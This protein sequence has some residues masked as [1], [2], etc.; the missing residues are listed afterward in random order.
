MSIV[1]RSVERSLLAGW[2]SPSDETPPESRPTGTSAP[3]AHPKPSY[4]ELEDRVRELDRLIDQLSDAKMQM[5]DFLAAAAHDL[6]APLITI[7]HNATFARMNQGDSIT[8][9]TAECLDRIQSAEEDMMD[10]LK[11]ISDVS[12]AGHDTESR[13]LHSSWVLAQSSLRQL[14]GTIAERQAQVTVDDNL[15]DLCCQATKFVQVFSNLISNAIKYTPAERTPRVEVGCRRLSDGESVFFV[16]DNG[17]GI[18]ED[19]LGRVFGIFDR[20]SVD[21]SIPGQGLGLAVV[22]RIIGLHGGRIW[23]ESTPG[24]GSTFYFTV[25]THE[26]DDHDYNS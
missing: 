15:P 22:K 13:A 23:V 4:E 14:E 1:E 11:Q 2:V 18:P 6:K 21:A 20:L 16:R 17:R 3:A 25:G 5:E 8:A 24:E 12:R 9:E 26:R 7:A 10:L 19:S